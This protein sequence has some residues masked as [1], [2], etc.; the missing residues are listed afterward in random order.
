MKTRPPIVPRG[1]ALE[2][3]ESQADELRALQLTVALYLVVLVIKLGASFVSGVIALLAEGLHTLSDLF[4]SGFLLAATYLSR[5][6]ADEEHM[7]GHGRAQ[8]VAALVAATL[9][10]SFTAFQLLQ[11]AVPRLFVAEQATYQNLPVAV[12]VLLVSMVIAAVP[13]LFLLR[14]RGRGQAA[15]AQLLELG[16][17]ELGLLAALTGTLLVVAGVPLGDPL[18]AIAVAGIIAFN[19]IRLLRENIR[20]LLGEAPSP[21]VLA[22]LERVALSVPGVL[23]VHGLRAEYIGPDQIRATLHIL[24]RRGLPIEEADAIAEEVQRQIREETG[25][26]YCVVHVDAQR[27]PAGG[28]DEPNEER[29]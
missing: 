5:K 21:E 17:D 22:N 23:G 16:N 4:I 11:E 18:A 2:T 1:A 15:R 9:F 25:C 14:Q 10:I 13:L 12:G 29:P 26:H 28:L 3:P 20:F 24:V 27:L 19:A 8:A 7:Y 6:E